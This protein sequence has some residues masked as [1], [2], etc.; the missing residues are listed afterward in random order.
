[1]DTLGSEVTKLLSAAPQAVATVR[2]PPPIEKEGQMLFTPLLINYL[3]QKS[4]LTDLQVLKIIT[5]AVQ[6]HPLY[7]LVTRGLKLI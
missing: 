2:L 5:I 4:I 6:Q 3:Y 1:M 7:S